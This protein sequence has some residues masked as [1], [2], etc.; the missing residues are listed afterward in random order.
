MCKY[1]NH[2]QT[3]THTHMLIHI[4]THTHTHTHAHT[5][6]HTHTHIY[7]SHSGGD[8]TRMEEGEFFGWTGR[9]M[10]HDNMERSHY[11]KNFDVGHT[12]GCSEQKPSK[13]SSTTLAFCRHWLDRLGQ[14]KCL[15][16]LKN[17]CDAGIVAAY[18]SLCDMRGSYLAHYEHTI[19]L[20]PICKEVI[21]RGEDY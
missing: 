11:M 3:H 4:H 2:T 9:A 19:L 12:C 6:T 20:R 10:V 16:G 13:K 21:S 15:M 5:H 1:H 14:T 7:T 17:L 18:P 8:A